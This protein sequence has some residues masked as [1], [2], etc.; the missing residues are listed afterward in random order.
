MRARRADAV[1]I[2][3]VKVVRAMILLIGLGIFA[4]VGLAIFLEWWPIHT[5]HGP[6]NGHGGGI[7]TRYY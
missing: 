3:R 4:V 2:L 6:G 5:G 7:R 1:D